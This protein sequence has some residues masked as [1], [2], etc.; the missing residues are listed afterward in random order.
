MG[1]AVGRQIVLAGPSGTG[2]T[3][4]KN[5]LEAQGL[6]RYGVTCTTRPVRT[7]EVDGKDYDFLTLAEFNA[8]EA[9]GQMAERTEY[10]SN[11]GH[12]YGILLHRIEEAE[13]ADLPTLW[14]L[15]T[16]GLTWMRTHFGKDNVVSIAFTADKEV[17]RQRLERRDGTVGTR[18]NNYIEEMH[19][20]ITACDYAFDTSRRTVKQTAE[21]VKAWAGLEG[22]KSGAKG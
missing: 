1:R 14:V 13:A 8:A 5:L 22:E 3:V 16:P 9:Y 19:L 20:A 11:R 12:R 18:L 2:K 4:T 6:V 17:L 10:L 7:G 21:A 15:D